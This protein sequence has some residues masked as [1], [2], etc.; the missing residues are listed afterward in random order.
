MTLSQFFLS[1]S[2]RISRQEY[3]L[4]ILSLMAITL[5]GAQ[6][7]DA[8]GATV[9]SGRMRAPSLIVTVWSLIL[10]WPS[11]AISI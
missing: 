8:E 9:E 4:G 7:L 5:V 6:L 10:A 2:G 11:T 1:P 3:W